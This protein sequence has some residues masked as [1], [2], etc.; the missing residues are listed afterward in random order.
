MPTAS[1]SGIRSLPPFP[2]P[3]T[4]QLLTGLTILSNPSL[5]LGDL[6]CPLHPLLAM[7]AIHDSLRRKA[8]NAHENTEVGLN[9]SVGPHVVAGDDSTSTATAPSLGDYGEPTPLTFSLPCLDTALVSAMPGEYS[10]AE[11]ASPFTSLLAR[12]PTSLSLS[13]AEREA[14]FKWLLCRFISSL[15]PEI[16]AAYVQTG[17]RTRL[18]NKSAVIFAAEH[19]PQRLLLWCFLSILNGDATEELRVMYLSMFPF[20]DS[21][22][23][24]PPHSMKDGQMHIF[25]Y[26]HHLALVSKSS[27]FPNSCLFFFPFI[28]CQS[29]IFDPVCQHAFVFKVCTCFWG[30]EC[31]AEAGKLFVPI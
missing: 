14:G 6:A 16:R 30:K 3:E 29:S 1:Q 28:P 24:I 15:F 11:S 25:F 8:S 9:T 18:V 21:R 22:G 4:S 26:Q 17:P 13:R 10:L 20:P 27:S 2:E 5:A 23:F 19:T 7:V 12:C 31:V